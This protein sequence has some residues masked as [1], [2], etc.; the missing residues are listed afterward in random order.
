[1]NQK[2]YDLMQQQRRVDRAAK[3]A[4]R[5]SDLAR[6]ERRVARTDVASVR[7]FATPATY[8][9]LRVVGICADAEPNVLREF[10]DVAEAA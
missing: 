10:S 6:A 2:D 7:W 8:G 1:M 9:P 5:Q 4:N 3:V